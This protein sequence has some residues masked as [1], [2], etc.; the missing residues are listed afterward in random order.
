[1]R[2]FFSGIVSAVSFLAL[3][4]VLKFSLPIS[5]LI[6]VLVYFGVF[7]ISKPVLRIGSTSVYELRDG[8]TMR[9]AYD[10]AVERVA[11]IGDASRNIRNMRIKNK[12]RELNSIGS[13]IINY[14]KRY[15]NKISDSLYFLDYYFS[16]ANKILDNYIEL[17][18]GNVSKE[19]YDEMTELS[20]ESM[21]L[22]L[23]VFKNQRDSY[24]TDRISETEIENEVL[25][26][27]MKMRGGR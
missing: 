23:S 18:M 16:T 2:S 26:R 8:E 5:A 13:D 22:L 1:M 11:K 6:G 15:P 10:K 24:Y 21:D 17:E 14:L 25:E 19:K 9:E 27:T 12:S 20:D 4:L 7:L 3:F